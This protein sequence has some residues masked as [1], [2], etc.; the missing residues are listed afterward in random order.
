MIG[1]DIFDTSSVGVDAYEDVAL[2]P[3]DHGATVYHITLN[4]GRMTALWQDV[5]YQLILQGDLSYEEIKA[6]ILSIPEE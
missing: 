2:P 6:I 1:K 4:K 3:I 5:D